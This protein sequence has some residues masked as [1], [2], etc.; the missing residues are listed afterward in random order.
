TVPSC[1]VTGSVGGNIVIDG[2][3][4]SL[5]CSAT[6]GVPP[7]VLA[8]LRDGVVQYTGTT[9]QSTIQWNTAIERKDNGKLYK[10]RLQHSTLTNDISCQ[11]VIQFDVEYDPVISVSIQS[12]NNQ[13]QIKEN[14][15]FVATC[16]VDDSYPAVDSYSWSGPGGFTANENI[17]SLSDIK[18]S[19][20]GSY[21]CT[22]RNTFHDGSRGIGTTH[23]NV[24]V[25]YAP[26][27][28]LQNT[29]N[30][31]VIEQSTYSAECSALSN[32]SSN[33]IEWTT[34]TG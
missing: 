2:D 11:S 28:I 9:S 21:T 19:S 12:G 1:S 6:Q 30:G 32:P 16:V 34:P 15:D 8:W 27:V 13:G 23:L 25:Q 33:S 18:R 14:D 31:K 24:D 3:T 26:V 10:C 29:N 7:A 5:Q 4:V 20:H 22:A 17:I